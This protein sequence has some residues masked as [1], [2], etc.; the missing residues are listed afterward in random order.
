[1]DCRLQTHSIKFIYLHVHLLT[2]CWCHSR[3]KS[4]GF[5]AGSGKNDEEHAAEESSAMS[6]RFG[7]AG[8]AEV[9]GL[10]ATRW[11]FNLHLSKRSIRP[12]SSCVLNCF[13][14]SF[15][16]RSSR[17][18]WNSKDYGKKCL[19]PIVP[20]IDLN[21][22]PTCLKWVLPNLACVSVWLPRKY[23][24]F[25]TFR[26]LEF[27]SLFASL[28]SLGEARSGGFPCSSVFQLLDFLTFHLPYKFR[29]RSLKQMGRF[30]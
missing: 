15:C 12:C 29:T 27:F 7:K 21:S 30:N 16:N 2:Y 1:M 14:S 26:A 5:H 28:F 20:E 10:S 17:Q 4:I 9:L 13:Q 8:N 19:S 18:C 11:H 25:V 3:V 6:P 24:F 22:I 23:W